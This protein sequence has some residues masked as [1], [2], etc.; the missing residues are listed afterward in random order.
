MRSYIVDFTEPRQLAR[1]FDS[2]LVHKG[3][4][5]RTT[6]TLQLSQRVRVRFNLLD[7]A[8]VTVVAKVVS[9]L[10]PEGYGLQ[11][12]DNDDTEWLVKHVRESTEKVRRVLAQEAQAKASREAAAPSPLPPTVVDSPVEN[13]PAIP[14]APPAN[15]TQRVDR[16]PASTPLIDGARA[17]A[18]EGEDSGEYGFG[19]DTAPEDTRSG[20]PS[21]ADEAAL[22]SPQ[23]RASQ[24]LPTSDELMRRIQELDRTVAQRANTTIQEA[25]PIPEASKPTLEPLSTRAPE[26]SAFREKLKTLKTREKMQ[27]AISGGEQI[28]RILMSHGEPTLHIWIFKNPRLSDEEAVEYSSRADL[29]GEAMEFVMRSPKW[30]AVPAVVTNLLRNPAIPASSYSQLLMVLPPESQSAIASS[31]DFPPPVIALARELV[32]DL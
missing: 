10:A 17:T 22:P 30:T 7:G 16:P 18:M 4:L 14:L 20:K 3:F 1:V 26:A 2:Y 32:S 6:D 25:I 11:L 29:S 28:R 19:E 31:N 21:A 27:L 24:L 9:I 15:V 13:R 12:P 5:L 23:Q 8:G